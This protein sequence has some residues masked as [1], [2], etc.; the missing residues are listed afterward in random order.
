MLGLC[1]CAQAF[2]SS[3]KLVVW[4]L[5]LA[6]ASLVGRSIGSR[7]VDFSSCTTPGQKL[8]HAGSRMHGLSS[9]G[10]MGL[11]APQHVESSQT[12]DQTHVPCI[13]RQILFWLRWV[14][15]RCSMRNLLVVACR[16]LVSQ[17]GIKFASPALEGG[18]LTNLTTRKSL[19][20][21]V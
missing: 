19:H 16:M 21:H 8:L 7:R 4:G 10:G 1:C 3:V 5:L 15:V 14:L 6:V 17:P 9:C 2:A 20:T 12:R 11:V 13:G 18:L